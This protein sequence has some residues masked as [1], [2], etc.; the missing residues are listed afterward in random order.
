MNFNQPG[1]QDV[2]IDGSGVLFRVRASTPNGARM[3]WAF[4]EGLT[5]GMLNL[6]ALREAGAQI[7]DFSHPAEMEPEEIEAALA[8]EIHHQFTYREAR[9]E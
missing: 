9:S 2:L 8:A 5:A 1:I 3:R 7:A 4:V 6:D